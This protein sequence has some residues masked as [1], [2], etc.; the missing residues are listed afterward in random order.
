LIRPRRHR[1]VCGA[2]LVEIDADQALVGGED[3][4]DTAVPDVEVGG[5]EAFVE[6]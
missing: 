3:A 6:G 2:G 1:A 5:G 4:T